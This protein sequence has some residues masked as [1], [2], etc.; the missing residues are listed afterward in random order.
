MNEMGVVYLFAL[1][2]QDLRIYIEAIGTRFPD[3]VARRESNGRLHR[4]L[5][6]F[7]YKSSGA[8]MHGGRLK[9]DR[10]VVVCWEHDWS[11]CPVEVIELK[12]AIRRLP[13]WV[14][15]H[16]VGQAPEARHRGLKRAKRRP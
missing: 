14:Y 11:E 3:A 10:H 2:A 9:T 8:R 6:E 7:E 4:V 15:I 1:V 13:N 16:R 12:S 5:L